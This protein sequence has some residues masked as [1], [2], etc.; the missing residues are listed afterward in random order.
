[1]PHDALLNDAARLYQACLGVRKAPLRRRNHCA[2]NEQLRPEHEAEA[3]KGRESMV[4]A[5]ARML[6]A[7]DLER[8]VAL[9]GRTGRA[10]LVVRFFL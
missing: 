4:K 7:A 3:I 6:Q 1:M 2:A 9:S 10:E 5:F 8:R